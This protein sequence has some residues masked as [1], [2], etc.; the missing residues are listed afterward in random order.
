MKYVIKAQV[1][2][3]PHFRRTMSGKIV[4]VKEFTVD[5]E[6]IKQALL[7]DEYFKILKEIEGSDWQFEKSEVFDMGDRINI[8]VRLWDRNKNLSE[9][10]PLREKNLSQKH[11]TKL[12]GYI[13]HFELDFN[14]NGKELYLHRLFL[15]KEWQGKGIG[16]DLMKRAIDFGISKGYKVF[17]LYADGEVGTYAWAIQG[18]DFIKEDEKK[19]MLWNFCKWL[20]KYHNIE[21]KP[22][23]FPHAWN[24]AAFRV[25]DQKIGKEY[26]TGFGHLN[27]WDGALTIGSK[28]YKLFQEYHR[29][30]HV[31]KMN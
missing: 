20:K 8:D 28:G 24:I 19:D 5:R 14:K 10:E 16:N 25:G 23:D 26:L 11:F 7:A 9:L 31:R 1:Q 29:L 30:R 27:Y 17:N 3:R 2:I 13:G 22:E 12:P 6:V 15:E 21:K 4:P 18:W